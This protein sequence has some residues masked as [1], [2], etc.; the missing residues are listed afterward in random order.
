MIEQNLNVIKLADPIH[1]MGP[2]EGIFPHFGRKKQIIRGF[3]KV[4][5]APPTAFYRNFA[6]DDHR[7][8]ITPFLLTL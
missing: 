1:D 2:K 8:I 5:S 7:W 3:W 6:H 4:L